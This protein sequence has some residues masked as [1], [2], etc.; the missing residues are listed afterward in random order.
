MQILYQ[1]YI[2]IIK[3]N[4]LCFKYL[5]KIMMVKKMNLVF[6]MYLIKQE[7]LVFVFV[8]ELYTLIIKGIL[9]DILSFGSIIGIFAANPTKFA[10]T[11]SLANVI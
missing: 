2:I 5:T 10:I 6:Q 3:I 11:I 4:N 1:S 9:I 8:L 7:L